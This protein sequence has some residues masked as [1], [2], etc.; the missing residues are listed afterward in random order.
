MASWGIAVDGIDGMDGQRISPYFELALAASYMR[1]RYSPQGRVSCCFGYDNAY[2]YLVQD[3]AVTLALGAD[4]A[5]P[6]KLAANEFLLLDGAKMSTSRQHGVEANLVL[7]HVPADLLRL[8]LAKLRPE[9][10]PQ[11]M[12][13]Q[14]MQM[15]VMLVSQYW[16]RWLTRLGTAIASETEGRAPQ[17]ANASLAPWP[18]EQQLFFSQ[19]RALALRANHG[20]AAWSLKEASIAIHEL[21]DRAVAFSAG[22]SHLAMVPALAAERAT[23]LALE[24]AAAR[25]LAMIVSPIMPAFATRLWNALGYGGPIRWTDDVASVPAGQPIALAAGALLPTMIDISALTKGA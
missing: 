12:T 16:Q 7:E 18:S 2:L 4:D 9:D 1:E 14:A 15:F 13:L 19:L 3:P 10:A 23:G 21:V 17:P 8:F 11:N 22:Q 24:L 20:Y 25:T 5:L 6:D